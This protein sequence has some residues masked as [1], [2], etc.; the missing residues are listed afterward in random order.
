MKSKIKNF[1]V[2]HRSLL[3]IIRNLI[4]LRSSI[5]QD[6][7]KIPDSDI[8][9]Y[10]DHSKKLKYNPNSQIFDNN[11]YGTEAVL[12][13]YLGKKTVFDC[14]IEH[15]L[16]FGPHIQLD[17]KRYYTKKV[18][19]FGETRLQH[20]KRELPE[21]KAIPIGPYIHYAELTEL[22]F[23]RL[24]KGKKLLFFPDHSTTTLSIEQNIVKN[25]ELLNNLKV[26]YGL[27]QIVLCL[28][29]LDIDA[30]KIKLYQE[31]G[32]DLFTSGSK[33]DS[34]FLNRLKSIIH[35]CDLT[36]S[37]AVGTHVGYCIYLNKPHT[38]IKLDEPK[39]FNANHSLAKIVDTIEN[40]SK[41]LKEVKEIEDEFQ[42]EGNEKLFTCITKSQYE[43]CNKYWGF[44]YIKD[45]EELTNIVY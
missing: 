30:E 14:Y 36:L 5:N 25:I 9:D 6:D 22:P 1:I 7:L 27:D 15:G 43:I 18:I 24:K 42:A 3:I 8:S 4:R 33:W 11:L 41:R 17:Q 34:S 16:F 38:I 39:T 45:K 32:F 12:K 23:I 31:A 21:K 28:Y 2:S 13:K 20:L 37:T 26:K 35:S 19:T 10:S 44:N 29:Y 40:D